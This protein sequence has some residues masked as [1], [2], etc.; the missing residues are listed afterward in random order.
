MWIG[1]SYYPQICMILPKDKKNEYMESETKIKY[2]LLM[3]FHC[4]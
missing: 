3:Y 4:P 1:E 2:L